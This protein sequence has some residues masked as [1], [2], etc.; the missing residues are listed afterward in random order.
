[1]G[2][3]GYQYKVEV[4]FNVR[5]I[6]YLMVHLHWKKP[7]VICYIEFQE[8]VST[9]VHHLFISVFSA[10]NIQNETAYIAFIEKANAQI[11][12]HLKDLELLEF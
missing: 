1:M 9:H 8:R 2:L 5:E 3:L 10:P 12:D 4:F 7:N 6:V 11:P